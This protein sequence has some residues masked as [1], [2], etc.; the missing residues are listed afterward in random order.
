MVDR[1]RLE[2][3]YLKSVAATQIVKASADFELRF[4]NS[5]ARKMFGDWQEVSRRAKKAG[6]GAWD[7]SRT[8]ETATKI[9]AAVKAA[10]G[11]FGEDKDGF[12][13]KHV[14]IFYTGFTRRYIRENAPAL[15]KAE[16]DDEGKITFDDE[17]KELASALALMAS[18]VYEEYY[19]ESLEDKV[20]RAVDDALFDEEILE[21]EMARSLED[22]IGAS[23]GEEE[24]LQ[25]DDTM[26]ATNSDHYFRT[27]AAHIGIFAGSAASIFAMRGAGVKKLRI[28]ATLD[29]RTTDICRALHNRVITI[30][31]ALSTIDSFMDNPTRD[32]F[33]DSLPY[34]NDTPIG[35]AGVHVP[36]WAA[37]GTGFPPYHMGCR[38]IILPL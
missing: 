12:L 36:G 13:K 7:G 4:E 28:V 15:K 14:D 27:T 11:N 26:F 38:T 1:A 3:L 22:E 30:G 8:K 24:A 21:R 5:L 16:Q 33:F 31:K 2:N 32:F 9:K 17:D 37:S 18:D 35:L 20:G 19:E 34:E 25:K 10:V 29:S 6:A 23:L